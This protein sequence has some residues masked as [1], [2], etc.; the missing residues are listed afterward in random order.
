MLYARREDI[1]RTFDRSCVWGGF[2]HPARLKRAARRFESKQVRVYGTLV[3]A[4]RYLSGA[5]TAPDVENYCASDHILI[6]TDMVAV[7]DDR[8]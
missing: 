3:P 6:V 1:G 4:E 2:A 8:R 7:A 5:D